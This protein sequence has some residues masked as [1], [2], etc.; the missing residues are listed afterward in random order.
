[1]SATERSSEILETSAETGA[2]VQST[3]IAADM[4]SAETGAVVQ[5]NAT[6]T[7][8]RPTEMVDV[9]PSANQVVVAN[10]MV[11]K[12][13]TR[14]DG[15]EARVIQLESPAT[16]GGKK[17]QRRGGKSQRTWKKTKGGRQTKKRR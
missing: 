4:S 5:S 9:S 10:D 17:K 12:L 8:M 1:M 15:L 16:F 3:G 6:E 11:G 13:Q 14:V 2:V 7:V